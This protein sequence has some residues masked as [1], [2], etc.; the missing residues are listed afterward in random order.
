MVLCGETMERGRE[1]GRGG[2]GSLSGVR[3]CGRNFAV[4]LRRRTRQTAEERQGHVWAPRRRTFFHA[5]NPV[6]GG[7]SSCSLVGPMKGWKPG[8]TLSWGVPSPLLMDAVG[9]VL[10]RLLFVVFVLVS[11]LWF[12][13]KK[14][15]GEGILKS[16]LDDGGV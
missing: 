7:L 5:E 16:R 9:E 3:S 4:F 12:W 8:G 2:G 13:R 10:Q 15:E 6:F 11:V 14:K 1:Q